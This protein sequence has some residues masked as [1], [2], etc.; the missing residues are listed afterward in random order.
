MAMVRNFDF[1]SRKQKVHRIITYLR[2]PSGK[3]NNNT[4]RVLFQLICWSAY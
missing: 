2:S 3:E 1:V 4:R